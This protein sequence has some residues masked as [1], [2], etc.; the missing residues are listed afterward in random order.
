MQNIILADG[1]W[2]GMHGIGRFSHEIL[3]RL[4]HCDILKTGP[5]PLSV[6]NLF[7]QPYFLRK[8]NQYRVF[9]NPGFNPI[10]FSPIP[11][12]LAIHDLIHLQ[13]PGKFARL[14]KYYYEYLIKPSAKKAFRIVTVSEY[15][16]QQLMQWA[17]IPA[18]KIIVVGTGVNQI[19]KVEGEKHQPGYP[20]LLHV[21]NTKSHKNVGRLIEAFARAKIDSNMH[22][23]LTGNRTV[24]LDS[25]INK[26]RLHERIIFSKSLS[27]EVLAKYYRGA[28]A[29]ILPSLYE[30]FG[31]PVIEAMACGTPV[32]VSNTTS[33]PEVAGDA[34]IY[35]DPYNIESI[36]HAIEKIIDD[37]SLRTDLNKKGLE[38]VKLFSWEKTAEIVQKVLDEAAM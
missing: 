21:S 17:N 36:T 31:I 33:L 18:E 27:D 20:Y 30:G 29:L 6:T 7:W 3:S 23:I 8:N 22:L 10:L 24:E 11:Y 26:Y 38:R 28:E 15:S 37:A 1:R 32:I 9:F 4:Q 34:A 14:K 5:R 12:V 35:I 16:K 13:F 25:I 19:F 2:H